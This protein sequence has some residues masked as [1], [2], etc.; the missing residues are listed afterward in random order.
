M[1]GWHIMITD[2]MI[3]YSWYYLPKFTYKLINN[4]KK[5]SWDDLCKS[6]SEFQMEMQIIPQIITRKDEKTHTAWF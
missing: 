5:V 2:H 1:K 3:K 6:Y 4:Q